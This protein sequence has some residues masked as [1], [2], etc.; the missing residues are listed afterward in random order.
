MSNKK[1]TFTPNEIKNDY[2]NVFLSDF[3]S[4]ED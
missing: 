1:Q 4:I 3:F 2:P